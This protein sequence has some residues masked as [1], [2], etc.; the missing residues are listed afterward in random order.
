[1]KKSG[2]KKLMKS[3]KSI[4]R[5]KKFLDQILFFC[6]FKKGQ[7]LIFELE[8]SLKLPK[9]QF[10]EKKVFDSIFLQFQ[11]WSKINF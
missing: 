11:K 8:K 4:S 9:M 1:M 10:H 7:K 2:P 6:H 3:N 5:K